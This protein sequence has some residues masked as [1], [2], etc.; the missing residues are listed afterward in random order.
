M[1]EDGGG[2]SGRFVRTP[3]EFVDGEMHPWMEDPRWRDSYVRLQRHATWEPHT[4]FHGEKPYELEEHDVP[5]SVP[6]LVE[7]CAGLTDKS[8]RIFLKRLEEHGLLEWPYGKTRGAPIQIARLLDP[9]R[10][11]GKPK[12]R[13]GRTRKARK[14]KRRKGSEG[15]KDAKGRTRSENGASPS[16][17]GANSGTETEP[18]AGG[19]G[20]PGA[21][22]RPPKKQGATRG[23]GWDRPGE[24]RTHDE[25]AGRGDSRGDGRVDGEQSP[26]LS[27]SPPI[28]REKVEELTELACRYFAP[29]REGVLGFVPAEREAV[30]ELVAELGRKL[31]EEG[32]RGWIKAARVWADEVAGADRIN[33]SFVRMNSGQIERYR[34]LNLVDEKA[35]KK[36]AQEQ[37]RR[38]ERYQQEEA[39][40]AWRHTIQK[41]LDAEPRGVQDEY[42]K[43]ALEAVGAPT[44]ADEIPPW[45]RVSAREKV[46]ELYAEEHDLPSPPTGG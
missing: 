20:H 24:G 14:G 21:N 10:L 28:E 17:P 41:E 29:D 42:M 5:V 37:Q 45:F 40:T 15:S 16:P 11:R 4:Y 34:S 32:A 33:A 31:G 44:E 23:F 22:S 25:P 26:S 38:R 35:R 1:A 18:P 6:W 9:W 3:V 19:E 27:E 13:K 8:A 39:K 36:E 12:V 7:R 30:Q 43:R 46:L 2:L